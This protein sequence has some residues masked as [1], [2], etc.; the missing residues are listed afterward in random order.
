MRFHE[1]LCC[2][3]GQIMTI[4]L[5]KVHFLELAKNFK[6]TLVADYFN[7]HASK[8]VIHQRMFGTEI[9][10]LNLKPSKKD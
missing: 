1:G 8:H 5:L 4:G 3:H 2:L 10:A 9:I 6:P 7:N